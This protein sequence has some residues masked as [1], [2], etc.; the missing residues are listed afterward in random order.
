MRIAKLKGHF[1]RKKKGLAAVVTCQLQGKALPR[2]PKT[3]RSCQKFLHWFQFSQGKPRDHRQKFIHTASQHI[4]CLG[5]GGSRNL[6]VF[7]L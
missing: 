4:S 5:V 7:M 1:H 6:A 2:R 3:Y